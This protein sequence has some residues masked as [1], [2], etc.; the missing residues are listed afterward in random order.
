V[1]PP[2]R[3]EEEVEIFGGIFKAYQKQVFLATSS[4]EEV[5]YPY[6]IDRQIA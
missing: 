6:M 5:G 4:D 2:S 3:D 1:K